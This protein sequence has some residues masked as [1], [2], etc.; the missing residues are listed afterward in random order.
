MSFEVAED[1]ARVAH[2]LQERQQATGGSG[3]SRPTSGTCVTCGRPIYGPS[4]HAEC[5]D[6]RHATCTC[7]TIGWCDACR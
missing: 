6:C 7:E 4:T 1:H 5:A 2:R 3:V